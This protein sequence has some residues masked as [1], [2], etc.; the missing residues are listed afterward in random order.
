MKLIL[1]TLF[2]VVVVLMVGCSSEQKVDIIMPDYTDDEI[3]G[4]IKQR[5]KETPHSNGPKTCWDRVRGN[6]TLENWK[7]KESDAK[8][9]YYI[10]AKYMDETISWTFWSK[11]L[12]I[13]P[14]TSDDIR[15]VKWRNSGC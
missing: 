15:H 9:R 10:T 11:T 7:V 5:L 3:V 13:L 1:I 4:F 14:T 2:A 12:V 6:T 8:G